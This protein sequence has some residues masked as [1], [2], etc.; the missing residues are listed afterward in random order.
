MTRLAVHSLM[1]QI[2]FTARKEYYVIYLCIFHVFSPNQIK[3][4]D[5][6]EIVFGAVKHTGGQQS[7]V[8]PQRVL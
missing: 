1:Y 6:I 4:C 3:F 8:Q 7:L 5:E 2:Y